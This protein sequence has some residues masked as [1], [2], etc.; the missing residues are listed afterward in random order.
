MTQAPLKIGIIG[1]TGRG[2]Y[3]HSLDVGASQFGDGKIMAIAD[4]DPKGLESAQKKVNAPKAFASYREMLEREKLDI[5]V[6]GPRWIDQHADML[7]AAAEAGC[8]VYMEKPFC[9]TL[10]ECDQVLREFEMR[11]LHIAIAHTAF[12]S[13]VTERV[14]E[15]IQAGEIGEIL[16]FRGRGK[17]DQRGG[18]EDLWVLGSHVLGLMSL[19]AG[20]EATNCYAT[21]QTQGKTITSKDVV[22]GNE[23]LGLIAGDQLTATYQFASGVTGHFASKRNAGGS[24]NRFALQVFGSKGMIELQT[25][26]MQPAGILRDPT[27]APYRSKK[28]W[29]TITS[30]GINK[31]ELER[32]TRY[33]NAHTEALRDL[34]AA[35]REQRSPKCNGLMGRRITE[36][37]VAVYAS[38]VAGKQVSLPLTHRE[39][40]LATWKP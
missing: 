1:A 10:A 29:E 17:E 13:P 37:I 15:A 14:L 6:I 25:G 9:R 23:G 24:E 7:L 31:P 12:Y 19:V 16:E 22:D 40:P 18:G 35:I 28:T 4:A 8:H 21:V 34:A 39:N 32:N 20:C 30:G 3:G 38:Q 26:Y 27:W 5:V 33:E 11:H 36:L 2:D